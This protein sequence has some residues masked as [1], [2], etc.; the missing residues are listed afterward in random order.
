MPKARSTQLDVLKQ[1]FDGYQQGFRDFVVSAPTGVGKT[2]V[3]MALCL[4]GSQA[5]T[6]DHDAGGYYL[7]T[8]K[9][10]Q[11]QISA[12]FPRL[13]SEYAGTGCSLKSA[14]EYP[15]D[16]YENCMVGTKMRDEQECPQKAVGTCPYQIKK[17]AF[18]SSAIG[19]TNY[20]YFFT[21]RTHVNRFKHRNV[22]VLDECHTVERQVRGFVELTITPAHLKEHTP[23]FSEVP[24]FRRLE[25]FVAWIEEAHMPAAKARL[26]SLAAA[27]KDSHSPGLQR[28]LDATASYVGKLMLA[29]ADIAND[30]SNWIFWQEEKEGERETMCKPMMVGELAKRL[31]QEQAHIRVYMS[32]YPGPRSAFCRSIGLKPKEV[33]WISCGS[34]FPIENRP[35]RVL[36]VGSMSRTYQEATLPGMLRVIAKTLGAH[37]TEKGL[38]HS[39]SYALGKAIYE[40]LKTTP[41]GYRV[42]FP[43]KADQR[44]AMFEQHRVS[45]QP[46]VLI[47]PSM[48]EGFSFDGDLARFQI[49]PKVPYAYLGDKMVAAK[50][51]VDPDWYA[52]QTVMVV[53]QSAGRIIRSETDKG[54]TYL[55]DADFERLLEKH[56]NFFPE[57]FREALNTP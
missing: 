7:V 24:V 19:V 43:V 14:I 31:I 28:Q 48:T 52:M 53:V 40:H 38:I 45:P 3:G 22:L 13:V 39:H 32:A 57:W 41:E 4:W 51:N 54:E 17:T 44:A 9:L 5:L 15:C 6:E 26:D 34:P 12:D 42:L 20:P 21:E 1:V 16:A 35:I 30:P 37:A 33:C 10:L 23:M 8:Q 50:M 36:P 46:T 47:S 25:Q 11:D 55:F 18:E 29:L 27:A 56:K 49:L 2:A